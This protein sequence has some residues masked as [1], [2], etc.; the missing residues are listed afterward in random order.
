MTP[1]CHSG[2]SPSPAPAPT[3]PLGPP[4]GVDTV[5]PCEEATWPAD[6]GRVWAPGPQARQAVAWSRCCYPPA[7]LPSLPSL[8]FL[9]LLEGLPDA[10]PL[11]MLSSRRWA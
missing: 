7:A 6:S 3:P 8:Y 2:T 5:V 11:P 1:P 4:C 9:P 10:A